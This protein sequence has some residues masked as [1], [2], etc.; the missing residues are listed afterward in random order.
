MNLIEQS[1]NL[2]EISDSLAAIAT[3]LER[4]L[5]KISGPIAVSPSK[6][7]ASSDY[8]QDTVIGLQ[9]TAFRTLTETEQRLINLRNHLR[10]DLLATPPPHNNNKV[11]E[12]PQFLRRDKPSEASVTAV[13]R[14][15]GVERF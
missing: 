9:H 8:P 1:K 15:L 7:D 13:A 6:M 2:V 5:E 11:E 3:S 14:D 10:E 4:E 12:L